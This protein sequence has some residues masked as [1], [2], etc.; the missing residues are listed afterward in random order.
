MQSMSVCFF[1]SITPA[2]VGKHFVLLIISVISIPTSFGIAS[3]PSDAINIS[4][5]VII[6]T[7]FPF[8]TYVSIAFPAQKPI[9]TPWLS[10]FV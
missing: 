3:K 6:G 1:S 9:I 5:I 7:V 4:L 10:K 8:T 2:V